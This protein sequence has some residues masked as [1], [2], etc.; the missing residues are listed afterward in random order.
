MSV[1]PP[2]LRRW[3]VVHFVADL[4]FAVPLVLAPGPTLRALGWNAQQPWP[5]AAAFINS[6]PLGP[7]LRAPRIDG[8]GDTSGVDGMRVGQ[9]LTDGKQ[10]SVAVPDG[11]AALTDVQARLLQAQPDAYAPRTL[12]PAAFNT[13]PPSRVRFTGGGFPANVPEL[14]EPQERLCMTLPVN[15]NSGAG[16][17]V[18]ASAPTGAPITGDS[19]IQG[20][21]QA[22][23]VYVAR[24]KG[25][26]V[27]AA[28][29]P[30]APAGSGTVSI[31]TD[32]ARRYP[33]ASRELLGRLGYGSTTP[34]QVPAQLISLLPQGPSLDATKAREAATTNQ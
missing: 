17:R 29:S 33:I 28:A 30:N 5:V 18:D 23:F 21:V 10:W 20:G 2:S 34:R 3:F 8:K 4:I 31:V 6:L 15:K 11:A 16:L 14:L 24:G 7:D 12:D 1:V 26:L 25:A 13:L 27:V 22:D 19:V 9:L 32:T